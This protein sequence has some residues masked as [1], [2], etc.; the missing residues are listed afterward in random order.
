M[1]HEPKEIDARARAEVAMGRDGRYDFRA[2]QKSAASFQL[3]CEVCADT[4]RTRRCRPSGYS[5]AFNSSVLDQGLPKGALQQEHYSSY[6]G[7]YECYSLLSSTL[8]RPGLRVI[9]SSTYWSYCM[10]GWRSMLSM[11]L[12]HALGTYCGRPSFL[13][14]VF[15]S[16]L[17]RHFNV[18]VKVSTSPTGRV[19]R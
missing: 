14:R 3:N 5:F 8:C 13:T 11:L 7:R 15:Q 18:Q 2:R 4:A 6:C 12:R 10:Y 9:V 1:D 16:L 17:S 19:D